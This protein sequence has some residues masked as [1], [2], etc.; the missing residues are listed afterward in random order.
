MSRP[1]SGSR[2]SST[3]PLTSRIRTAFHERLDTLTDRLALMCHHAGE[4]IDVATGALVHADLAQA[5]RVFDLNEQ[6]RH[7]PDVTHGGCGG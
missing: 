6:A 7:H 4:V 2:S 5:E 3:C 1:S